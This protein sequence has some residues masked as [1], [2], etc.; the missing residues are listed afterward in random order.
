MCSDVI[1][2]VT[3][4]KHAD[5]AEQVDCGSFHRPNMLTWQNRLTVQFSQTLFPAPQVKGL[6][7]ETIWLWCLHASD[8]A[9]MLHL[10]MGQ[11]GSSQ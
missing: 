3:V 10:V 9:Y 5:L 11:L 8:G 7:R 1:M 4:N 6:A 2:Y